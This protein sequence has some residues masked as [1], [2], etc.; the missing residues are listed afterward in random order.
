MKRIEIYENGIYLVL[1]IDD[2]NRVRLLHF[3]AVP[4][5]EST[6]TSRTGTFGFNLA[7]VQMSGIDR[8][9]ERHGNKYIVTSPG[10]TLRFSD[11]VDTCNQIGRKL[12]ITQ[13][14][15]G[16]GTKV[17]SHF[18]FYN[19]I[20]VARAWTEV[21]NL[22]EEEQTLE[23]VSSFCLTGIEKEG[24][25]PQDDKIRIG[26]CHNS[27]QR[28]LQWKEYTLEQVGLEQ[29][30]PSDYQHS[31]K[32]FA[33]TNV[34]NWSAKEYIPMGMIRNT[35][36]GSTLVWQIEQNGSWHWEISD[37]EGHLY[38]QLSGPS[39]IES[40]WF[41]TLKPGESFTSVKCAV[42]V[43]ANGF[44]AAIGELTK[45]RR[46]IR[47]KNR[48]NKTLAV[49]FND[50]MNCLW[51]DPTAQKE[52]PLVDAAAEAG[53]DY[54]CIDAGWYAEGSW[55]DS[56]GEWQENRRRFPKGL[57]EVTDYIRKKGMIPGVW[58][59]IEVM[60]INCPKVSE[61]GDDWFF[62]RHGKRVYDRSRYQLDFRNPQVREYADSVIDRLVKEYGVGYI[63]MDYNI[64]P[65]IGTEA[66]TDSVG[67]GL[68]E[69]ER[70][71]LEWLDGVFKRHKDLIIEN[72]SSG[73]LRMDYAMLSRY[74]IQS[75]SD[76]DDYKKYCT[77]AANA[78]LALTPEQAAVWSYPM[79]G[80]DK[81]EVVFNM[82]NAMLLRIHQSGHLANLD[83]QSKALVKQGIGVYKQIRADIREA[84]PFW[85]LGTSSFSDEW[86]SL[87]LKNEGKA[88]IAVWRR[89]SKGD[90]VSLPIELLKGKN[91]RVEC[92]YPDF[93]EEKFGWNRNTSSLS[94]RL[95]K[96]FSARLFRLTFDE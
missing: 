40:H 82:I 90:C 60:G 39:E 61:V 69:H 76:Q 87:G 18:Q 23:Y 55:W 6:L 47:R 63:K 44:D 41:K 27:W 34:G 3:S 84:L 53:C 29:A 81:E 94:V 91:V 59:E 13:L 28:E 70:A 33:C 16:T 65:G 30:Q 12:E 45:Y 1:E 72:C 85:S 31:S 88:Y 75:T 73:G 32:V 20:S 77:I 66:N 58:L 71:Y 43:N 93:N 56:V 48:D 52:F 7:E 24:V 19:G 46:A 21:I 74:S 96:P 22:G 49:I 50:Y 5:D 78:P 92:I 37:R 15:E 64:E 10:S 11:F 51:G 79:W 89:E 83:E 14:D 4:F 68:L 17:V 25:L 36:I 80:G 67:D 54:F 38:L 95:T 26:V 57:K 62:M 8:A 86:V 2:E 42:G 9:G 35:E